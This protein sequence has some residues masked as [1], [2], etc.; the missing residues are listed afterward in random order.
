MSDDLERSQLTVFFRLILVIPHLLWLG[1][2]GVVIFVLVIVN[3][4]ATLFAGTP[5]A[6]IHGMVWAKNHRPALATG[7]K[8]SRVRTAGAL[9]IIPSAS[10]PRSVATRA[11]APPMLSPTT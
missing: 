5:P 1:L 11:T 3:W 9:R 2:W 4:F 7:P 10:S 6:G 8:L